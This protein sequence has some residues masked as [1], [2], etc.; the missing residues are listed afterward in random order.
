MMMGVGA[1]SNRDFD[2]RAGR[3]GFQNR[4]GLS[5]SVAVENRSHLGLSADALVVP[6]SG[7]NTT[8]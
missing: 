3:L 5:R 7:G 4:V 6:P 2:F 1:V 8:A